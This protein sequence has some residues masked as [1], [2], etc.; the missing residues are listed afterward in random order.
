MGVMAIMISCLAR[1]HVSGG[2]LMYI[3]FLEWIEQLWVTLMWAALSLA[4]TTPNGAR[5]LCL[6]HTQILF[7]DQSK[8][9]PPL[10]G[11]NAQNNDLISSGTSFAFPIEDFLRSS[12]VRANGN[13]QLRGLILPEATATEYP[14]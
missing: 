13:W 10:N 14:A 8:S 6:L 12:S 4:K 11:W 1:S 5:S 3:E 2:R 9:S 7:K